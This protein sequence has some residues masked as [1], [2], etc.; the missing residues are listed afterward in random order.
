LKN[1][2]AEGRGTTDDIGSLDG[3]LRRRRAAAS[4]ALVS[5]C[6]VADSLSELGQIGLDS[7][8]GVTRTAWTPALFAAYDWVGARMRALGLEVVVDPAGNLLGHWN[9]GHGRAV[10]LGSH[11]DTV[12][13][14]GRLDGALGVV[15]AVHAVEQL[16]RQDFTPSRPVWIAAFM[17]EEGSRFG[18][19]YLGSRAFSGE[20]LTCYASLTDV[21]GVTLDEALRALGYDLGRAKNAARIDD[22]HAYLELHIEQGPVLET[23]HREIGV[24]T[25]IVGQRDYRLRLHGQANHAGTT[26]MSLRRDAFVGA[27]RAALDLRE[28]ARTES[29]VTVN[30]GRLTVLPG[31]SNIVP[32]FVELTIDARGATD[33]AIAALEAHVDDVVARV[34]REEGLE[35]QL[36]Q[37]SAAD[38]VELDAEL[39]NLVE[40][41]ALREGVSTLRLPSGA[42]HDAMVIGRYV[43]A[44]MIFVPSVNGI[45]HS[46]AEHTDRAD[47]ERGVRV[48]AA[49]VA[50]L[51]GPKS[52]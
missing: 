50:E 36:E 15:G 38:P 12:P 45:S 7:T 17:D 16:Q 8:G 27:S 11:L 20:D 30:I 41:I 31:A 49:V 44:A 10:L 5:S 48:L 26:P 13:N 47:L 6:S 1:T 2:H 3:G 25:S 42:G 37:T 4:T 33:A 35:A 43:P 51:T 22:I 28:Y 32:G 23:E 19:S 9:V 24:V 29:G 18:A 52:Q 21:A 34:A 46:P 39:V 14:G 40:R